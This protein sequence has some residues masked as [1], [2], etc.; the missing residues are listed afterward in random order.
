MTHHFYLLQLYVFVSC[1]MLWHRWTIRIGFQSLV[2]FNICNETVKAAIVYLIRGDYRQGNNVLKLLFTAMDSF[3]TYV[4][5]SVFLACKS[6]MSSYLVCIIC[7]SSSF[8]NSTI[9]TSYSTFLCIT[10]PFSEVSSGRTS[11]ILVSNDGHFQSS[12]T[13]LIL[14]KCFKGLLVLEPLEPNAT[15]PVGCCMKSFNSDFGQWCFFFFNLSFF[16]LSDFVPFCQVGKKNKSFYFSRTIISA[17][18]WWSL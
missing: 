11:T 13:L 18:I 4:R 16:L 5:S 14:I 7:F 10:Y 15:I 2:K 3:K 12:S 9:Y 6:D 1:F 8:S 17:V